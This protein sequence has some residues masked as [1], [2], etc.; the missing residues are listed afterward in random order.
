MEIKDLI[1]PVFGA[2]FGTLLGAYLQERMT[3]KNEDKQIKDTLHALYSE[4]EENIQNVSSFSAGKGF[5]GR[6]LNLKFAEGESM[7]K[8]LPLMRGEAL[9]SFMKYRISAQDFNEKIRKEPCN[10][11]INS[12]LVPELSSLSKFME[13]LRYELIRLSEKIDFLPSV[14]GKNL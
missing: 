2:L 10:H 8:A 9:V 5:G 12:G 4:L 13:D 14:K 1:A 11:H 7:A 6:K 3:K